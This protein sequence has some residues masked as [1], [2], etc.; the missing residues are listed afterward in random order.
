MI[1]YKLGGFSYKMSND[2]Y[3]EYI[4]AAA[5]NNIFTILQSLDGAPPEEKKRYMRRWIW[6]LIQNANDTSTGY[7][8][9]KIDLN[10]DTLSFSHDG[11]TFDYDS[12]LSLITQISKKAYSED[13]NIGKFGTGFIT[14]CLLN[15]EI[16]IS[17]VY[18]T[19][20]NRDVDFE[21]KLCR[22]GS[23]RM[24]LGEQIKD[25]LMKLEQL[26]KLIIKN[27][28]ISNEFKT[29]F[30]YKINSNDSG[31]KSSIEMGIKD[32]FNQVVFV[33]A[34]SS[35]ISSIQYNSFKWT[36]DILNQK[37]HR[38]TICEHNLENHEIKKTQLVVLSKENT[39]IAIIVED[40]EN[41]IVIKSYSENTSF[42][43]CQFPL[44]G[45]EHYA[46]PVVVNNKDFIVN[47]PRSSI[48]E[49]D[50]NINIFSQAILLYEEALNYLVSKNATKFYNICKLTKVQ[51][52][53]IQYDIGK[54]I[55]SVFETKPIVRRRDEEYTYLKKDGNSNVWIPKMLEHKNEHNDQLWNILNFYES[56]NLVHKDEYKYWS[57]IFNEGNITLKNIVDFIKANPEMYVNNVRF[58]DEVYNILIVSDEFENFKEEHIFLNQMNVFTTF[59]GLFFDKYISDKLKLIYNSLY[60]R[61]ESIKN[62]NENLLNKDI[63]I[64]NH[65]NNQEKIKLEILD[66][67]KVLK[68]IA[69]EVIK[70][71][72][73]ESQ[74]SYM[75]SETIEAA[76]KQLYRWITLNETVAKEIIP[77]IY[78]DRMRLYPR[79]MQVQKLELAEETEKVF[80]EENVSSLME[81]RE[82]YI[83]IN[84]Q[85]Y[86]VQ[87]SNQIDYFVKKENISE[88]DIIEFISSTG[89]VNEK[90]FQK[91]LEATNKTPE[92]I[93]RIL[94][95]RSSG[96]K[97]AFI[98]IMEKINQA[99]EKVFAHLN[100]LGYKI[101]QLPER[102]FQVSETV[103]DGIYKDEKEIKL[104]IRPCVGDKI[105]I[106]YDT[107]LDFLE[108]PNYELWV[109]DE[110]NG[111]NQLTL[112]SI[113]KNTGMRTIPLYYLY[114][115]KN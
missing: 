96:T 54:K 33:L 106:Y 108:Y 39:Q 56:I 43:F 18:K 37:D 67:E 28:F 6:E 21:F 93:K 71:F 29:I 52:G 13:E 92:E 47:E 63:T 89:I 10:E 1:Q 72:G 105:I 41:E 55:R 87:S 95:Y 15:R 45:S 20:D 79:E 12:L 80:K 104:I 32:L 42:L 11:K 99:N 27:P 14:T 4:V 61:N 115:G 51:E 83:A 3:F 68:C 75:R 5:T 16:D 94:E 81:L 26:E 2:N 53:T 17:G 48:L 25:N 102:K 111:A 66:D 69:T 35:K 90:L 74:S 36:K 73:L 107:E 76:Y 44:I 8:N 110:N 112:G 77:E 91:V 19:K 65:E 109:W 30:T 22:S 60:S 40:V 98:W 7:L 86:I 49:N 24:K 78:N 9:I 34:F 100:S 114:G 58:M 50:Y 70:N 85:E 97:K 62:L 46:F 31:L 59:K 38:I 23:D 103:F 113:L 84:A 101:P 64:F 88:S 57:C 82:K